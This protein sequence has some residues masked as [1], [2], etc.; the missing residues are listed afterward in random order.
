VVLVT[1]LAVEL[2]ALLV[3]FLY[4][5]RPQQVTVAEVSLCSQIC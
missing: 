3:E 2:A 1:L 4:V 5:N